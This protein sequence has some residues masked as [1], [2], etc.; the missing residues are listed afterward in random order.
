MKGIDNMKKY[1]KIFVALFIICIVVNNGVFALVTQEIVDGEIDMGD[2][3][4]TVT[5]VVTTI[6]SGGLSFPMAT[7]AVL[8]SGLALVLFLTLYVA[9]VSTGVSDLN[10]F[11]FPDK[12]I[13]NRMHLLDANFINPTS[14]ND[15]SIAFNIKTIVSN[16][17]ESFVIIAVAIFVIITEWI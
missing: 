3:W 9:F 14:F 4:D 2:A 15:E 13:F 16:L 1:L 7:T 10:N 11:P 12:V 8:L 17:F 5:D 6:I